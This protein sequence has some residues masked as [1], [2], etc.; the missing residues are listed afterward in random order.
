MKKQ[1]IGRSP[2]YNP[3]IHDNLVYRL[4]QEN[5][6]NHEIFTEYLGI[7]SSTFYDWLNTYDSFSESYK[8]GKE[9]KLD[10]VEQNLYLRSDFLEVKELVKSYIVDENGNKT[11]NISIKETTKKIPPDVGAMAFIL[12]TQR[13]EKWSEKQNLSLDDGN[14]TINVQPSD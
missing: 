11:G 13:P 7:S 10:K 5:K 8:K 3:E 9:A 6:T 12:K 2:K 4:R 14:I 1:K